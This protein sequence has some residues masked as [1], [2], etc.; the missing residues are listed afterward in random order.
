MTDPHSLIGVTDFLTDLVDGYSKLVWK[1][2][3]RVLS[4]AELQLA[5][6]LQIHLRQQ[7]WKGKI[8]LKG[9]WLGRMA[10]S[11]GSTLCLGQQFQI[12]SA[13]NSAPRNMAFSLPTF[14]PVKIPFL[15]FMTCRACIPCL[16][17]VLTQQ[18]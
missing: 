5:L 16:D 10:P 14:M 3:H 15:Y 4:L 6:K 9:D 11:H 17:S 7:R 13:I 1:R 8:C 18:A 2:S 12:C